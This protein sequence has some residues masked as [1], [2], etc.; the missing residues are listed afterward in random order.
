[1]NFRFAKRIEKFS[2]SKGAQI[3]DNFGSD[4]KL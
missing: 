4:F 2:L 3:D 1:M